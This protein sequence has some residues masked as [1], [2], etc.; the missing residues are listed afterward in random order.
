MD[1]YIDENNL[2]SFLDQRNDS[3]FQDILKLLKRQLEINFNFP[4]DRLKE[5]ENLSALI[6]IL[7]SGV[8]DTQITF[9][10]NFPIRPLKANSATRFNKHQLTSIYWIDDEDG[11]KLSD[12]GSV[13]IALVGEEIDVTKKLFFSQDDY[14]F[15]R[16]WRIGEDGL[17]CW[18]DLRE[19]SLPLTDIIIGDPFVLSKKDGN[20][21]SQNIHNILNMLTYRSFCKT[22]LVVFVKP[23][24]IDY[25]I[26]K[27]IRELRTTIK[28]STGKGCS[29]TIIKTNKEHDRT[30]ITNYKR[31]KAGDSFTFWSDQGI[32]L[33]KGK[34][35]DYESLCNLENHKYSMLRIDDFQ[36]IIDFNKRNNP[37]YII[38]DEVSNFL[39]F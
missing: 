38:G 35:L 28:E 39:N 24:F 29:V 4:K 31:I 1:I 10:S 12:S 14:I 21:T 8:K 30:I 18:D 13:F 26:Q 27:I 2:E 5:N 23:N 22:S 25:D 36:N 7:T 20:D 34:E 6:P 19:F 11:Y 17:R 9:N 15:N 37:D 32:L 16:R 33:S 3:L